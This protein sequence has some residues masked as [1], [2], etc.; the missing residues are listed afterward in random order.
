LLAYSGRDDCEDCVFKP[1]AA[2]IPQEL[3][4]TTASLGADTPPAWPSFPLWEGSIPMS[5]GSLTAAERLG[6]DRGAEML[7]T[8]RGKLADAQHSFQS[9]LAGAGLVPHLRSAAA[10]PAAERAGC[11]K[12]LSLRPRRT[13]CASGSR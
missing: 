13:R 4:K 12:I 9:V 2:P 7:A 10:D 11:R 1:D 5:S 8:L 6:P 3:A